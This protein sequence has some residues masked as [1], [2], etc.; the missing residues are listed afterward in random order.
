M[1]SLSTQPP[2]REAQNRTTHV[3]I[4]I[5]SG[6]FTRD[7][8]A[9]LEVTAN[10]EI[11]GR[12]ACAIALLEGAVA[13]IETGDHLLVPFS[14]RCFGVDQGLRFVA[15]LLA[16]IRA[17]NAAQEMQRAEDF[18]KSLQVPIIG[19]GG[20]WWSRTRTLGLSRS[21]SARL[22]LGLRLRLRL[23]W[24]RRRDLYL[25]AC[26]SGG[27]AKRKGKC[28]QDSLHGICFKDNDRDGRYQL[29]TCGI[30]GAPLKCW[31]SPFPRPYR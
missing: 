31:V 25:G 6:D 1:R 30:V 7:F 27:E 15:P 17:A 8:G 23:R 19:D 3:S 20:R 2:I 22:R 18:G 16:F 11:S 29:Q 26:G 4:G 5:A 24:E 10:G 14:G 12:G 21:L 13:A 28:E 9:L